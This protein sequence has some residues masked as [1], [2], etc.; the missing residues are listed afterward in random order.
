MSSRQ[1]SGTSEAAPDLEERAAQVFA[2]RR[3]G[4]WTAGD[5]SE[6]SARLAQD[7]P[8]A[9]A[10]RRVEQSW[11]AVGQQ[12]ASADVMAMRE[13]TLSRARRWRSGKRRPSLWRLVAALAATG[14][15]LAAAYELAPFGWRPG[16]YRTAIGEQRS[17][18]LAD[19]SRIA[20][21]AVTRLRVHF[22]KDARIVQLISGQAQF[23]VAKDVARPFRVETDSHV[24]V[25]VGTVF[26]VEY[27]GQE[28]HV[29]M[30]EGRVAVLAQRSSDAPLDV[31]RTSPQDAA[32][33]GRDVRTKP[34]SGIASRLVD[35][36]IELTAGEA[37]HVR[38]DGQATVIPHADLAAA[39]A[40]REG[41]VIFHKESLGEAVR[42]LNRYSSLQI[43]ISDPVLASMEVSGLFEEGDSLAFVEAVQS[44]LPVSA[45][46]STPGWVRLH[47][48]PN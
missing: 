46:I 18:E 33:K 40:W 30:L 26:T 16:E 31:E 34:L 12:A 20:L 15:A 36:D 4:P 42:Q 11:A 38:K 2:R 10:Y 19:H 1:R 6:L 5:E 32:S 8:Y 25:A 39:T 28:M 45:D 37:L 43:E 17:I 48:H 22:S 23:W 3:F 29:A 41:K 35:R 44:S 14:F 21:D 7:A 27:V 13:R 47:L 9:D 24:V